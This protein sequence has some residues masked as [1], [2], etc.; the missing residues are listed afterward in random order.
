MQAYTC[1]G[2]DDLW[3]ARRQRRCEH[4]RPPCLTSQAGFSKLSTRSI[5]LS[6]PDLPRH[7]TMAKRGVST[8]VALLSPE[9]LDTRVGRSRMAGS[10]FQRAPPA[11]HGLVPHPTLVARGLSW[12]HGWKLGV[13][14]R[15]A[16]S[17]SLGFTSPWRGLLRRTPGRQ[18]EHRLACV[19]WRTG[20]HRTG[21]CLPARLPL[22]CAGA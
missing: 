16:L 8:S 3:L 7:A 6:T 9:T 17:D 21:W 18:R 5:Y 1:V 2:V 14:A 19:P 13:P 12:L 22:S 11:A 4:A 20:Q 15:L 10:T